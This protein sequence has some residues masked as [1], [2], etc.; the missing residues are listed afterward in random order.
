[1]IRV[2][3]ADFLAL[4][5]AVGDAT[6]LRMI[7]ALQ[8]RPLSVGQLAASV[9]V[10]SAAVSYHVGLMSRAGL[11]VVARAGRRTLVKR[12]ARR[13]QTILAAFATAE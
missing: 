4:A 13:W 1:M 10:T 2:T 5:R 3:D 8:G 11:V 12:N 9:G 7:L 6:R